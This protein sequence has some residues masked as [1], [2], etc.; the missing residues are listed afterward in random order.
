ML[1]PSKFHKNKMPHNWL[2]YKIGDKFIN[3]HQN[4]YQGILVDLGC[5]EASYKQY[6]LQTASQYIGVDWSETQHHSHADVVSDLNKKVELESDTADTVVSFAVL[7]H[8]SEPQVFLNEAHR[9]LKNGGHIILQVPWQW[10]E[11][12][13]PHD[14]FRYSQYGLR[15]LL[16][17]AGFSEINISAQ[18]GIFT[19]LCVKTNYFFVRAIHKLPKYLMYP[20]ALLCLPIWT[21]NQCLA[22][23]FDHLDR[24]WSNE[25]IGHFITA[26]KSN[27]G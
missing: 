9:I 25:T 3:Q 27:S 6:F 12:E 10:H 14:Y 7:E 24:N 1:R 23:L 21:I 11:H 19:T 22:P 18:A 26:K 16:T 2:I 5:G 13:A 8:L 4:L 17:K 20:L 15:H